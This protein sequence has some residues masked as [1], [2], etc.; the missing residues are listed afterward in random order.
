MGHARALLGLNSGNDIEALRQKIVGQALTVRQA[1]AK[2]NQMRMKTE[3]STK[4]KAKTKDARR[5]RRSMKMTS[6]VD[7]ED[8]VNVS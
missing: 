7:E 3:G 1:E 5:A 4:K 8:K 6:M 2:V